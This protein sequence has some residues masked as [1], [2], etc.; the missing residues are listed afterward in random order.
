LNAAQQSYLRH[1]GLVCSHEKEGESG[2]QDCA[3]ANTK[4]MKKTKSTD[5]GGDDDEEEGEEGTSSGDRTLPPEVGRDK[6]KFSPERKAL[7]FKHSSCHS[8]QQ[9]LIF[10]Y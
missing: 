8:A 5:D 9:M 7:L 1:E 6:R 3:R 2:E 4:K 10:I